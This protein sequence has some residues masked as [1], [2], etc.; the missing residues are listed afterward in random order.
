MAKT[1][2]G[3]QLLVMSYFRKK[4]S[5]VDVQLGSKYTPRFNLEKLKNVVYWNLVD[6]K[7]EIDYLRKYSKVSNWLVV[8]V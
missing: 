5:I 3:F 4:S 1:V 2:K 7:L 6:E 8:W